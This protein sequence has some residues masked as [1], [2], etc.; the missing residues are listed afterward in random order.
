M[1]FLA[2]TNDHLVVAFSGVGERPR[3]YQPITFFASASQG[4]KNSVLFVSDRS[5]SWL[6]AAGIDTVIRDTIAMIM[7]Q[8][9][10]SKLSLLGNSMGA[11][12][13]LYLAPLT[14]ADVVIAF[15]PQYA[16]NPATMPDER[17]WL[18]FRKVISEFKYDVVPLQPRVGQLIYIVHGGNPSELR[19]AK[20]FPVVKGV[21]HFIFPQHGHNFITDLRKQKLLSPLIGAALDG[22]PYRFRRIIQK[23]GGTWRNKTPG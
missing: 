14:N 15:T 3:G 17:R 23:F 8:H 19:H 18:R 4:G 12:M 13:A 2:G 9:A 22:R 20:K 16:A 1:Q 7:K 5:R 6:N 21:R 11:S 10:L